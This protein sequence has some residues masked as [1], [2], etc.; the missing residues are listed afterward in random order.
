MKV[1]GEEWV[2]GI[3]YLGWYLFRDGW[4]EGWVSKWVM[5]EFNVGGEMSEWR[6]GWDWGCWN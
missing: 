6:I 5:S 4:E 3:L 1:L 2:V